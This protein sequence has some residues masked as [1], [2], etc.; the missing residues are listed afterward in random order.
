MNPIKTVLTETC[1]NIKRT[2]RLT[3]YEK[4]A[5][6][7]E[8]KL[9]SLWEILNPVMNILVYWFVFS[10]GLK[11]SVSDDAAYPYAVWLICGI[12][13]WLTINAT[14]TQSVSCLVSAASLIRSCNIPLSIF[15]LKSVMHGAVNHF[16]SIAILVVMLLFCR[17]PLTW[18][19]LE[20]V[21]YTGAMLIFLYSFALLFSAVNV[22]FNDLQ[23]LLPAV[24]RLLMYASSVVIDIG[25]FP[26][27][28]QYVLR[29]NP[30]VH[31]I[32]GF[33]FCLLDG[34]GIFTHPESF[35]SFWCVTLLLF[36]MGCQMHVSQRDRFIDVL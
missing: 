33:R 32:E 21:Y 34:K 35:I 9:G 11:S 25:N 8:S 10:V 36:V 15:P 28:V 16:S 2:W 4:R 20:I 14:M 27:N 26:Q 12:V 22:F 5:K 30:L 23:K 1:E 17:I 13:V 19:V 29:L 31:L 7:S 18:H 24:L 6:N 3:L